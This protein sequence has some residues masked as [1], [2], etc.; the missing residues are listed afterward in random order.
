M[1]RRFRDMES[2]EAAYARRQASALAER[3]HAAA[4]K[5][6]DQAERLQMT[7]DVYGR[8]GKDYSDPKK[9][10]D[11]SKKGRRHQDLAARHRADAARHEAAAKA[12][13]PKK[14]RGWW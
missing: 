14:K 5:H 11:A 12:P 13:A 7:V 2:P 3:S 4:A 9:A 10:A 8:Q 1:A 6:D